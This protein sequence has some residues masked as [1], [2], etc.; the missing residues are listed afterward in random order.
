MNK[1]DIKKVAEQVMEK[2]KDALKKLAENDTSQTYCKD[3]GVETKP[4]PG[5]A[6]CAACWDD[7]CGV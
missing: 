7:K 2:H 3:C 4:G 5:S 6:R 1:N